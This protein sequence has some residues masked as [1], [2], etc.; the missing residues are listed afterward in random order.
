[1]TSWFFHVKWATV[2]LLIFYMILYRA[3]LTG[4]SGPF[5]PALRAGV[6]SVKTMVGWVGHYRSGEQGQRG[7]Q[8]RFQPLPFL[9]KLFLL[10]GCFFLWALSIIFN[11]PGRTRTVAYYAGT[12]TNSWNKSKRP[13]DGQLGQ[14]LKSKNGPTFSNTKR[15]K[16]LNS[17]TTTSRKPR[18]RRRLAKIMLNTF[19]GKVSNNIP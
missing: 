16:Q 11:K 13:M 3:A 12:L 9:L 2:A 4:R 1:M 14:W 8:S 18:R 17:T 6:G 10:C 15:M 5:Q 19:W 7:S